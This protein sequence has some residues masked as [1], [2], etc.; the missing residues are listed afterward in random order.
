VQETQDL[1]RALDAARNLGFAE[2]IEFGPGRHVHSL[3]AYLRDPDGHR[4][5]LL[6]PPP[7]MI[8]A[9]E[10]VVRHDVEHGDPRHDAAAVVV[11]GRDAVRG[12][13]GGAR[14]VSRGTGAT[15]VR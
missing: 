9:D 10:C 2:A 5:A 1:M 8:D 3:R 13:A 14:A 7:Q 4:V 12:C 11:R 15:H 6:L